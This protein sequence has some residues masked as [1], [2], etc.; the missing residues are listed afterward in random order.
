MAL[1][2]WFYPKPPPPPA[3]QPL[4]PIPTVP[5]EDALGAL[6]ELRGH[7]SYAVL[8]SLINGEVES[9]KEQLTTSG[10]DKERGFIEGLRF[11][12]GRSEAYRPLVDR[13][14]ERIRKER[15]GNQ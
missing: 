11:I 3:H 8:L 13:E 1:F 5:T 15:K 10:G 14:I 12:G 2:D 4:P 6:E 7:R 9:R